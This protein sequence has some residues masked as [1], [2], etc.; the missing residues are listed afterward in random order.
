M[1]SIKTRQARALRNASY[2]QFRAFEFEVKTKNLR[3]ILRKKSQ[4][5]INRAGFS[6]NSINEMRGY[7]VQKVFNYAER[8]ND[9]EVMAMIDLVAKEFD[10]SLK[11]I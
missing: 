1:T 2:G 10:L 11:E 5:I 9:H 8:N 6:K 4:R 7:Y 3:V